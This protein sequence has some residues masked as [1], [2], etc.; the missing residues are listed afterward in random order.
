MAY[1]TYRGQCVGRM[2]YF[3]YSYTTRADEFIFHGDGKITD[4]HDNGTVVA[5][6]VEW[7]GPC[8]D[9]PTFTFTEDFAFLKTQQEQKQKQLAEQSEWYIKH[10]EPW[11]YVYIK[12]KHICGPGIIKFDRYSVDGKLAVKLEGS[13]NSIISV[14]LSDYPHLDQF[15]DTRY[16]FWA[17]GYST[18]EGVIQSLKESTQF[19]HLLDGV[20]SFP[21][22]PVALFEVVDDNLKAKIDRMYQTKEIAQ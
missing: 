4:R 13:F 16:K 7:G 18:H 19:K 8:N 22:T 10:C 1:G 6:G 11:E 12:G 2:L 15:V 3:L 5:T 20:L 9:I 17:K 14:N 21:S